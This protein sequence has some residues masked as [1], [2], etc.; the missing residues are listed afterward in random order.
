[1]SPLITSKYILQ[2]PGIWL[3][4]HLCSKLLEWI[5]YKPI[6]KTGWILCPNWGF[7]LINSKRCCCV[8][9]VVSDSVRPHRQQPTRLPRPWDS[10]GKNT[11]VQP[12]ISIFVGHFSRVRLL[13][14]LWIVARQAPLSILFSRQKHWSG[15]PCPP[16]RD[17]PEPGNE[18]ESPPSPVLQAD[19]LPTELPGKASWDRVP[20]YTTA[21]VSSR[22]APHKLPSIISVLSFWT[23]LPSPDPAGA[24]QN[25]NPTTELLILQ[26]LEGPTASSRKQGHT[27]S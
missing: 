16:P 22:L 24:T 14:T 15:L 11:G 1:M 12:N 4:E 26:P 6:N 3:S 27:L 13:A 5:T 20:T 9:S 21:S 25:A 7:D 2:Y 18:P 8:A 17:L 10:P 23:R 19:Y